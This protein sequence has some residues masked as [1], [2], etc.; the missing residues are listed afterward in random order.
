MGVYYNGLSRHSAP[1]PSRRARRTRTRPVATTALLL[2]SLLAVPIA[3][4]DAPASPVRPTPSGER[5]VSTS[6]EPERAV[7]RD[8]GAPGRARSASTVGLPLTRAAARQRVETLSPLPWLSRFGPV[9]VE[10]AE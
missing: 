6:P 8:R 10:R 1:S 9:V 4:A 7:D 2:A 5:P 3:S